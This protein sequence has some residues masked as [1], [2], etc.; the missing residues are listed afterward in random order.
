MANKIITIEQLND[1]VTKTANKDDIYIYNNYLENLNKC[2]ISFATTKHTSSGIR[3][4]R[5]ILSLSIKF[6]SLKLTIVEPRV[7]KYGCGNVGVFSKYNIPKGTILTFVPVSSVIISVENEET[8]AHISLIGKECKNDYK[9]YKLNKNI[10][11]LCENEVSNTSYLGNIIADRFKFR[12]NLCLYNEISKKAANCEV[13]EI[14]EIPYLLVI[15]STRD[16]KKDEELFLHYG[17]E[18]Y[19]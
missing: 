7:S 3:I 9:F 11:C 5:N 17:V 13:K 16:I 10:F 4:P 1:I 6:K 14:G 15:V 19:E 12:Q 2:G 8:F 18:C